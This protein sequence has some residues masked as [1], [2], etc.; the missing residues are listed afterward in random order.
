[1]V[2]QYVALCKSIVARAPTLS[3]SV[4]TKVEG[5]CA[6]AASGDTEGARKAAKEV[7]VEVVNASPVTGSTKEKALAA[8]K[9]A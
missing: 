8:C 4:K 1:V 7:C 6:K 5:I 3:A 2:A 9:A